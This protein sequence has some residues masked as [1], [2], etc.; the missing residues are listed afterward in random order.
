MGCAKTAMLPAQLAPDDASSLMNSLAL[1]IVL[2]VYFVL[3]KQQV[4]AQ[5]HDF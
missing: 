1:M 3:A 2:P 5:L 4:H